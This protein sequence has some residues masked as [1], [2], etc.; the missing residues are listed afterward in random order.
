MRHSDN[1]THPQVRGLRAGGQVL[2]QPRQCH[3]SLLR[4][5]LGYN[6]EFHPHGYTEQHRRDL[7]LPASRRGGQGRQDRVQEIVN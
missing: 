7:R 2:R 4:P 1:R 3:G 5:R 6:A